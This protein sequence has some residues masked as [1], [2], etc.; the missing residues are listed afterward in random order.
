MMFY[1]QG[2]AQRPKTKMPKAVISG[3]PWPKGIA[4][5]KNQQFLLFYS[6]TVIPRKYQLRNHQVSQ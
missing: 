6:F 4:Q 5:H 2:N 3:T 1:V